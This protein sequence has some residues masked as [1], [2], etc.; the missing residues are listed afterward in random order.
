MRDLSSCARIDP[1]TID[2]MSYGGVA[3]QPIYTARLRSNV[4]KFVKVIAVTVM[5][6]YWI[7]CLWEQA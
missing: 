7:L 2:R 1:C 4:S 3:S 6:S 5:C